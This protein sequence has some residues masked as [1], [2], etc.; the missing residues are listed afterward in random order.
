M[1]KGFSIELKGLQ[2]V[3]N[4][5]KKEGGRIAQDVDDELSAGMV[6]MERSAKRL[7]PV[8]TGTGRLRS[9]ITASRVEF[10][11]WELV[12]QV[13]YAA[14]VEFGTGGKEFVKIPPGLES[15]AANFQGRGIREVNL[16]ARP[17]FFPSV[18]AYN[19]EIA[20]GIKDILK[21]EKRI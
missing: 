5:L 2:G 4:D 10:L 3:I 21:R 19:I 14:Y 9:S 20:K 1:A 12:A 8:N 6:L 13:D 16:P 17:Y 11:A 15:Y 18:F 7:A